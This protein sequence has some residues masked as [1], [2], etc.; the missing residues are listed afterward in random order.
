MTPIIVLETSGKNESV[1]NVRVKLFDTKQVAE[2]YCL[3][4]SDKNQNQKYWRFAEI[5]NEGLEYEIGRYENL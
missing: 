1:D 3:D 2:Q 4:V 5:I